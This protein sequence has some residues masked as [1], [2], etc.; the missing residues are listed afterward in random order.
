MLNCL[1]AS[2]FLHSSWQN[3]EALP[4]RHHFIRTATMV[5]LSIPPTQ[6]STDGSQP[7][8]GGQGFS[9][10]SVLVIMAVILTAVLIISQARFNHQST[11]KALNLKQS[12]SDVNQALITDI[13]SE[14]HS[15]IAA[16]APCLNVSTVM[17]NYGGVI[18]PS[19]PSYTFTNSITSNTG[20]PPLH[21]SAAQRCKISRTPTNGSNATDNR[22]YF[23]VRLG[24]DL[25]APKDSIMNSGQA[26]AEVAVELIDLQTQAGISC[27][28]YVG[29]KNDPK[30]GSAGMAVTMALYWQGQTAD[31]V[32]YS[33]KALSYIAN[34]N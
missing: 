19:I 8:T 23:C 12:Y 17:Q 25:T 28:N 24:Q 4:V 6:A 33:Q 20:W 29:K 31:K 14:I 32:T 9:L 30:D 11:Q 13:M 18:K 2:I 34:Q 5:K 10:V 1:K 16:T 27:S 15:S 7:P 22:L 3:A 26:F 21:Q